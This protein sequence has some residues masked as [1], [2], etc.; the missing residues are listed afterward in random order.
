MNQVTTTCPHCR[1]VFRVNPVDLGRREGLVKCGRCGAVFNGYET[2]AGSAMSPQLNG[3][4]PGLSTRPRRRSLWWARGLIALAVLLSLAT[5]I[6]FFRQGLVDLWPES[7]GFMRSLFH[8]LGLKVH[9]PAHPDLWVIESSDM[10]EDLS[11]P[12]EVW[13]IATLRNRAPYEEAYPWLDLALLDADGTPLEV[14]RIP[15]KEYFGHRVD[16]D[17][18]LGAN[19]ELN[20][21]LRLKRG[22]LKESGYRLVLF[23][24]N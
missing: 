24:P 18:G 15:P 3:D 2:V 13:L 16:A 20:I 7:Q 4:E 14:R 21:K 9:P 6:A 8:P 12:S 1:T 5:G 10:R 19:L 23:Y 22:Q 17:E 11:D